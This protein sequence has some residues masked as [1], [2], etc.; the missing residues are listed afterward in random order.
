MFCYDAVLNIKIF[1][2]VAR[3]G[4]TLIWTDVYNTP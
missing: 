2:Y 1:V 4:D 3:Y